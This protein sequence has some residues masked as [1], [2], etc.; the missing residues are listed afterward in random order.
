MKKIVLSLLA[1]FMLSSVALSQKY[2]FVDMNYILSEIPT[3]KE[4][5]KQLD[6][7]SEKWQKE[8]EAKYKE[9]EAKYKSYQQEQILL[10]EDT[11]RQR[12]QEIFESEKAAKELQKK[13]FGVDGSMFQKRKELI[14]PIQ[15]EIYKAIKTMAKE[16]GYDFVMEKE[17]NSNILY[18]NP[19]YD[20]SDIVLNKLKK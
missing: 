12:E 5:Q 15:D 9:I 6:D 8:I 17:K 7:L 10:P 19:K 20:K 2:A 13:R 18:A 4:A 16:K 3:Y 14:E 1:V 11:K